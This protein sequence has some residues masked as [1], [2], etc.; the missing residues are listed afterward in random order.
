MPRSVRVAHSL[1]SFAFP[2][3]LCIGES[4][5]MAAKR[6]LPATAAH[7]RRRTADPIVLHDRFARVQNVSKLLGRL[8]RPEEAPFQGKGSA[9]AVLGYGYWQRRFGGVPDVVGKTIRIETATATI[10]GVS[11]SGASATCPA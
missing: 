8:F 9:V 6:E 2:E 11:C 1:R 4:A 7:P 3:C 5:A 10:V